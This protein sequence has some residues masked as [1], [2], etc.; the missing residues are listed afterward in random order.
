MDLS[1]KQNVV[2]AQN[3]IGMACRRV[4]FARKIMETLIAASRMTARSGRGLR[5]YLNH[6]E[7][8]MEE[9]RVTRD[10]VDPSRVA[11]T[12]VVE[13]WTGTRWHSCV[14]GNFEWD[15]ARR[16]LYGFQEDNPDDKFRLEIYVRG[17]K[18]KAMAER[19]RE[20]EYAVNSL[21]RNRTVRGPTGY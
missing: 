15:D 18:L 7:R 20:L 5:K 2:R 4:R 11:S 21:R 14:G 16:I 10:E 6:K 8:M 1:E 13:M 17:R 12:Y 19:I 3:A 9:P